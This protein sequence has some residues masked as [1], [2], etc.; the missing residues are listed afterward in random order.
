[1]GG[2]RLPDEAQH[3][4]ALDC[5]VAA[6]GAELG[7]ELFTCHF[8]VSLLRP[9]SVAIRLL[10]RPAASNCSTSFSLGVRMPLPA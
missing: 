6:A 9:S 1:M 2:G 3:P 8:T 10:G 4:G 5:V 7:K